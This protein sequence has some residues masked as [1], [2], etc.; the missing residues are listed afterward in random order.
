MDPIA[1]VFGTLIAAFGC[2]FIYMTLVAKFVQ[3]KEWA[4]FFYILYIVL[5]LA[6]EF[7]SD[8]SVDKARKRLEPK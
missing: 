5:F 7:L 3:S 1:G 2:F 4:A 8:E 6:L